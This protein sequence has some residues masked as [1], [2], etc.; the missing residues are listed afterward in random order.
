[1]YPAYQW[2]FQLRGTDQ[3]ILWSVSRVRFGPIESCAIDIEVSFSLSRR[4]G[5]WYRKQRSDGAHEIWWYYGDVI[6][7]TIASQITGVTFVYSIVCSSAHWPLWG[8]FTGDRWIPRRVPGELLAQKASN[9]D[10]FHLMTS[11]W[12]MVTA[13][14]LTAC[15][16]LT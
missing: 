12:H 14:R 5:Q 11:S 1:M 2:W 7:S 6:M 16:L 10:F 3:D 9:A 15:S 4:Y 8:E 13:H